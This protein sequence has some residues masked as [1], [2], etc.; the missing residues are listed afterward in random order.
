MTL[1]AR[2]VAF[3]AFEATRNKPQRSVLWILT[4]PRGIVMWDLLPPGEVPE[5]KRE[6][7]THCGCLAS[8]EHVTTV[9]TRLEA[10]VAVARSLPA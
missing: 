2:E 5:K 3:M 8:V 1:G 7:W 10:L 4:S 6:L 9:V